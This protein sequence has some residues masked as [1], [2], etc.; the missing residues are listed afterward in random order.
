VLAAAN[1]L[2]KPKDISLVYRRGIYGGVG[3]LSVKVAPNKLVVSRLVVVVGKK[4]DKRAVVRNVIRRRLVGVAQ[5]MWAT[6]PPGYDI[7]VSVHADLSHRPFPELRRMLED[8]LRRA[9]LGQV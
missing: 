6:L 3:D 1:R 9:K 7:V 5:E 4:V 2:R 8:A